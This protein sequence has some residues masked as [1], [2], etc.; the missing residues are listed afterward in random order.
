MTIKANLTGSGIA[1]LAA[2]GIAGGNIS[3]SLT[4]AGT[5]QATALA[6]TNLNDVHVITT[7]ASSTGAVL[8]SSL[9][10]G[11]QMVVVNGGANS[12]TLYPPSGGKLNNGT[13]NAGLAVA[14]N[15]AAHV[16]CIDNLNFAVV[17]S[18]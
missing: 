3:N 2:I 13:A 16:F 1:P 4:A 14:A 10:I 6:L 5:T 11:D 7:A 18:A 12:I 9:S 15:K 8:P 17:V